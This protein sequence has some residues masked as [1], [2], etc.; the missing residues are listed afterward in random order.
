MLVSAVLA[1]SLV[2]FDY[3][4]A[5]LAYSANAFSSALMH[6]AVNFMFAILDARIALALRL[7]VTRSVI[8]ASARV[9]GGFD[10]YLFPIGAGMVMVWCLVV[11]H[12]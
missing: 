3:F 4:K 12:V 11:L 7:L 6:H 8:C 9:S 5:K 2:P 10:A 1:D